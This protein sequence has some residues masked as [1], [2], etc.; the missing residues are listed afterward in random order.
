MAAPI[1]RWLYS[2][3]GNIFLSLHSDTEAQFQ[4]VAL[5]G[6]LAGTGPIAVGTG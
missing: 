2:R 1:D 5:A 4:I 3:T 6:K